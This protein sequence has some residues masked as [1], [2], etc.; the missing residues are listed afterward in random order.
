LS[1]LK[2]LVLRPAAWNAFVRYGRSNDSYRAD[3]VVSGRR[4]PIKP[5]PCEA[6]DFSWA[7]AEK[8]LVNEVALISGVCWELP[9]AVVPVVLVDEEL[10]QPT[11]ATVAL[12]QRAPRTLRLLETC[13]SPPVTL[14]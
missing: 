11:S 2:S 5:F 9:P 6:N 13:M 12:M 14:L 4:T 7:I 1:I 8:S 10:L 3:E